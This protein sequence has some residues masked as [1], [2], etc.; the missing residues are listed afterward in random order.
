MKN[1]PG[2]E[3]QRQIVHKISPETNGAA[4]DVHPHRSSECPVPNLQ[5]ALEEI[6]RLAAMIER[7]LYFSRPIAL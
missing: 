5:I 1:C 4:N 6:S 2:D 3:A 7:L